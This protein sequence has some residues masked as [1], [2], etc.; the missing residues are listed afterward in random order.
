MRI[1]KYNVHFRCV[2]R[3]EVSETEKCCFYSVKTV[4][5]L[6]RAVAILYGQDRL[7][8]L[9]EHGGHAVSILKSKVQNEPLILHFQVVKMTT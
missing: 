3:F 1:L 4:N 5:L 7:F 6:L 2:I 8:K 9:S